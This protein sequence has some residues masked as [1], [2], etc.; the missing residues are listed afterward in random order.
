[1]ITKEEALTAAARLHVLKYYPIDQGGAVDL[2][3]ARLFHRMVA[4]PQQLTWLCDKLI[5]QVG[6]YP[7]T[8]QIRAV[9]CTRFK[10]LD[11]IEANVL[12]DL[13][14][15]RPES[16]FEEAEKSRSAIEGPQLREIAGT[17]ERI[18]NNSLQDRLLSIGVPAQAN[19]MPPEPKKAAGPIT[20]DDVRHARALHK[21]QQS[22]SK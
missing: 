7:G 10:P 20:E 6:F 13:P 22:V 2:E 15:Y 4:T 14:I 5:D 16:V 19:S 1:M 21:L 11:G 17:V 8:E 3:V 18:H 9:F 12:P